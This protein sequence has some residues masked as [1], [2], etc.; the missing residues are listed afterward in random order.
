MSWKAD[1]GSS[2]RLTRLLDEASPRASRGKVTSART[3]P[4]IG[5]A[6]VGWDGQSVCSAAGTS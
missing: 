3:E 4:G 2:R 6:T 1:Q 5:I